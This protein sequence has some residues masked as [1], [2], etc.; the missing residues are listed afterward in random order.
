MS[1]VRLAR[2]LHLDLRRSRAR[3]AASG[4]G[5]AVA[6]AT[7]VF[8]VALA[9]GLRS[10]LVNDLLPLDR[11]EVAA[12]G[13][14]LGVLAFRIDLGGDTL[15]QESIE[16]LSELAGVAKVY[17][18]MKL[19]VPA[20]A[21][22]G[23]SLLGSGVRTDLVA[24]GIDPELVVED[25][26][27]AFRYEGLATTI[28][29]SSDRECGE[30][31]YCSGRDLGGRGVCRRYVPVL[32]SNHLVELY[33]GSFRR[34]YRLPLLDPEA[35]LG[36]TFEMSFGA[37]TIRRSAGRPVVERM[38]LVGFSDQAMTLGV[39]LPLDFV[40]E[41]NGRFGSAKDSEAYH[42]AILQLASS[43]VASSV[44]AAVEGMDLVVTDRGARRA[45]QLM[46]LLMSIM[47]A[48]GAAVLVVAAMSVAHSFFVTVWS[49][50]R[51]IGVLR[52]IGASRGHIRSL[53]LAEAALVGGVAGVVGAIGATA[54]ARLIDWL[55]R[56]WV[57]DFPYKPD[58]FFVL[59]PLLLVG[60][61]ALAVAACTVG[62]SIPVFR[63][64]SKDPAEA[65]VDQ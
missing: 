50:R 46:A 8:L 30:E 61:V 15:D 23:G 43:D 4:V 51:E 55:G 12:E 27:D 28:D 9:L 34:A 11:L 64:V 19:T 6:V 36:F 32:A 44:L 37:S 39:T 59:D 63:V 25:V 52:A 14:S 22:G 54:M 17:P 31:G 5:I 3:L 60:A 40:R 24:D 16:R 56:N 47:G 21:S 26:G 13:K 65:L 7:L 20:V 53:F 41:L 57:P 33:N 18:K 2:L 35:V 58:S 38:R 48:V 1:P 10:T 49:R 29:C 45:A 42:S 62:A